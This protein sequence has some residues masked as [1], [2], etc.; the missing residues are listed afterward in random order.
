MLTSTLDVL[1]LFIVATPLIGILGQKFGFRNLP[2][3]SAIIGFVSSLAF[4]PSLYTQVSESGV[5]II[6][7]ESSSVSLMGTCLEIDLLSVFMAGIF[8]SI[9]LLTCTYSIRYMEHDTRLVEYYTL[10]LVV[11]GGMVGVSFAGDL[12]TL[13]IF[14][15]I[16][17]LGSYALVAFRKGRWEPVEAGFKYLIMSSAGSALVLYAMSLLY[18]MTG[19]LNFA[20]LSVMLSSLPNNA[21]VY[22]ALALIIVGFGVL[23]SIAPFHT[24]LPDAHAAA[25]SPVSAILSGIVIKVGAY[26]LIRCLLLVFMPHQ[27]A[28]QSV[29]MI[30]AIFTMFVGNIMA[31]LQKDI[32]RLLG[33]S[34]IVNMGYIIF[35]LSIQ[36]EQGLAG[37]TFHILNHA[38]MKALLFLCV[39]S[40]TYR[41]KTRNLEGLVG[42]GRKMPLTTAFFAIGALA[43]AGLP[44]LN[45]FMSEITIVIAGIDKGWLIPTILMVLNILLSM[46]Y[47]LRLIHNLIV[48]KPVKSFERINEAPK[49]MLGIMVILAALCVVIGVYPGPFMSFA[50][51]A[52]RAALNVQS[53]IEA[54]VG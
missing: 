51:T 11:V 2:I 3:I 25:P 46:A 21:W 8:I 16:M 22:L 20:Y 44:G 14:W 13:F 47:Y 48:K 26:A 33:F 10:L 1:F 17:C 53:Y 38:I 28:W 29:L 37:G 5:L 42:I 24:W 15:E 49:S 39:G 34:S 43:V 23:A 35:A 19:S 12:F 40:Y 7:L 27:L 32:K 31:L 4:L 52:A 45:G 9:G 30:L 18:G 41:T 50:E 6:T 54:V 36:T